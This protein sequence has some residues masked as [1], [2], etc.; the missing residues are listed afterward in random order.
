MFVYRHKW[1]FFCYSVVVYRKCTFLCEISSQKRNSATCFVLRRPSSLNYVVLECILEVPWLLVLCVSPDS[2][3]GI[4][5]FLLSVMWSDA[6]YDWSAN[7]PVPYSPQRTTLYDLRPRETGSPLT[8][9]DI[10]V[11]TVR[12]CWLTIGWM[13]VFWLLLRG[14][15]L[16]WYAYVKCVRLPCVCASQA[17]SADLK[18]VRTTEPQSWQRFESSHS[19]ELPNLY[20]AIRS[21]VPGWG[22]VK[23]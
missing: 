3:R 14:I 10:E 9:Q 13:L 20:T 17:C 2:Y 19:P 16:F 11:C 6:E 23:P 1:C 12:L 8:L 7:E 15:P 21:L 18:L 4:T 5:D 22:R